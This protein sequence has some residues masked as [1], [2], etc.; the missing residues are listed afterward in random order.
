MA[1]PRIVIVGAGLMGRWHA[2]SAVKTGA[3]IAAIVD[4]N[5]DRAQSL[6]KEFGA[7][8]IFATL[9]ECLSGCQNDIAHVCTPAENHLESVELCLNA[10]I[11]VL[12]E[13]PLLPTVEQTRR[14]LS[15]ARTK[16]LKLNPVHQMPF[17]TGAER[18]MDNRA[19]LG[20]VVRVGHTAYTSGGDGKTAEQRLE[21][22]L[23]IL[24]HPISL[25]FRLFGDKLTAANFKT[26]RYFDGE[27]E[28]NG[29]IDDTL[30]SISISLR[31]RPTRNELT[32]SGE[33][34]T[35][36]LDLFHGFVTFESG[37]VSRRSKILKP[38]R[39]GS[40]LLVDAS[41]NLIR[42]SASNEFAY[43]GLRNL[44]A[45]FYQSVL[46]DKPAPISDQEILLC[47]EIMDSARNS[48]I[49]S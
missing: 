5:K 16:R 2:F 41:R 9:Q 48:K 10:G 7:E 26:Q 43:P 47:A 15:V 24:P 23:E 36:H 45:R 4:P 34:A 49:Q 28:M 33:Q 42:R 20:K 40:N 30:L 3:H 17:Q 44:I 22:L 37:E 8:T 1:T 39:F 25:F 6:Q 12:A 14:L 29:Q 11:H 27:L 21:V 18:M 13:K 19:S 31:G 35:A 46:E 38:F 32:V